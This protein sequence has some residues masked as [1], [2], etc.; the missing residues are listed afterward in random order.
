[1]YPA[2]LK[3]P[4][5][6]IVALILVLLGL[7]ACAKPL[8]VTAVQPDGSLEILGPGPGFAET[9]ESGQWASSGD[10]GPASLVVTEKSG[11]RAIMLVPDDREFTI[12][13]PVDAILLSSSYL[14]WS[15]FLETDA[16]E[17]PDVS[18]I[19]GFLSPKGSPEAPSF[20][21]LP[22]AAGKTPA[23]R[24]LELRWSVS[25]LQ[26]GNLSTLKPGE[27]GLPR[28]N[29]R[30]G[31]ENTGR[32]WRESVDLARLY[33]LL[34]PGEDLARTRIV[35]VAIQAGSNRMNAPAYFAN[36]HLFR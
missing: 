32:W 33:K 22:E 3:Y 13:R 1:M 26:R 14:G 35:F 34:W 20:D 5:T 16:M 23:N 8:M 7:E 31:R 36:L 18:I 6:K 17:S 10:I 11:I 12:L 30:G 27:E 21:D 24:A 15:W 9:F 4:V 2:I 28:Y 29:V 19:V 25:A